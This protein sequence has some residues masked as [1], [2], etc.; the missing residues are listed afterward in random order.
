M[1]SQAYRRLQDYRDALA[2]LE[3]TTPGGPLHQAAQYTI[4]LLGPSVETFDSHCIICKEVVP[5]NM[6]IAYRAELLD[7]P[8]GV[9]GPC[10][11]GSL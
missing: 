11:R 3:V 6:T 4:E 9:C 2:T 5:S 8:R 7:D 10:D 1:T